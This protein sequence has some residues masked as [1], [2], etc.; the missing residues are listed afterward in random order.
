MADEQI[1]KKDAGKPVIP[2]EPVMSAAAYAEEHPRLTREARDILLRLYEQ[3]RKTQ[4]VWGELA[5]QFGGER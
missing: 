1:T 4:Q 3:E 2:A 5:V